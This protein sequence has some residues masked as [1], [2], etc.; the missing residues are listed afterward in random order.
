MRASAGE[1]T[2][3][4][5]PAAGTTLRMALPAMRVVIADDSILL[6]ER[7]IRILPD[8]GIDVVGTAGDAAAAD[9]CPLPAVDLAGTPKYRRGLAITGSRCPAGWVPGDHLVIDWDAL[10]G[11]YVFCAVLACSRVRFVRFADNERADTTLALLAECFQDLGGI[12][13]VVLTEGWPV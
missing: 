5:P 13:R 12:P 1:L 9:V 2:I 3:S 4:S 7:L 6:R 8:E 10:G 11:L